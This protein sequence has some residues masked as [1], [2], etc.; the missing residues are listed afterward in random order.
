VNLD[1]A[2]TEP[3]YQLHRFHEDL[4]LHMRIL[5]AGLTELK[6]LAMQ[7]TAAGRLTELRTDG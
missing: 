2:N 4:S 6:Q 1:Q 7:N 5:V 3:F